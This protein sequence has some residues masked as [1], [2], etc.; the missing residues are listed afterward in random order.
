MV[1]SR[2]S[3]RYISFYEGKWPWLSGPGS[4]FKAM[5]GSFELMMTWIF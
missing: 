3:S 5:E 2:E 4:T 1:E